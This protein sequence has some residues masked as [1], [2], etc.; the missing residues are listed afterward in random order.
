LSN[1]FTVLFPLRDSF[2]TV[3][4]L[5]WIVLCVVTFPF[6]NKNVVVVHFMILPWTKMPLE[7]F[8]GTFTCIINT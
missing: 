5:S 3:Q 2:V 7:I 8:N 6:Q 1:F 4:L